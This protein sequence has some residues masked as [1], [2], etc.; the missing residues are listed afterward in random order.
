MTKLPL[1]GQGP[2]AP[3]VALPEWA[4]VSERRRAHIERVTYLLDGWATALGLGA[5]EA[6]VWHDAGRWHDALRDCDEPTLRAATGDAV[7]PFGTLHGPAAAYRLAAL[8]EARQEVLDAIRWHTVGSGSWGRAGKAL[9]MADYLEPGRPFAVVDRGFLAQHV[10]LDFDGV[11][12]QVV[13][14]RFEWTLREGKSLFPEA[15]AMWNA[16]R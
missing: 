1:A 10:V 15:V 8:G 5:A 9:Y 7:S 6:Q 2:T 4:V 3:P 12:R 11:F 13:R 16:V 14:H